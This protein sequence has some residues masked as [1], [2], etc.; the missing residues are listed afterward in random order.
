MDKKYVKIA[1]ATLLFSASAVAQ[2]SL[3]VEWTD[4]TQ[5]RISMPFTESKDFGSNYAVVATPILTNA[6][7]DTLSLEPVIFRGKRNMKYVDRARYFGTDSAQRS[8]RKASR[9]AMLGDTLMYEAT[10]SRAEH[11]WLWNG[12]VTVDALREKDGCCNVENLDKEAVGHFVYI[13][14][15][16]PYFAPVPDDTGEAGRLEYDNPVLQHISKYRP[17]DETR[18][19]SREEGVLFVHFQFDRHILLYDYR[20]NAA[21]LDRIVEITRRIMADSTSTVKCIQIIGLASVEGPVKRNSRLATNRAA[22]LKWYIQKEVPT[23]DSLYECV[24][25]CEGWAELRAQ[26]EDNKEIPGR[27]ELLNIID[28]EPNPDRREWRIKKLDGGKPFAYLR[29]NVL[30]DQRN[31]GYLRIYYDYVPDTTAKVINEASE[32]LK[33]EQ[34]SEALKMLKTVSH[35]KRA[36]NALG[37]AYYMTGNEPEAIECFRRAAADGNQQ[38]KANLNSYEA[39]QRAKAQQ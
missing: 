2:D 10:F 15:F 1:I 4:S 34:Y 21:T 14:P 7:G 39:I 35:D 27:D 18:V 12:R 9:E 8:L 13:P 23:P 30:R 36:Q 26:I 38:A 33:K 6:Q 31:S 3:K 28:T 11:P 22:A 24:D 17:Y 20:D 29:D 19:L 37:V 25:G 5:V 16:T 32:L